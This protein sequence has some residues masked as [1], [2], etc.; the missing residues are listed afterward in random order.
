MPT[1]KVTVST[2]NAAPIRRNTRRSKES[3]GG[4]SRSGPSSHAP[5]CAVACAACRGRSTREECGQRRTKRSGGERHRIHQL[6]P[7]EDAFDPA[8]EDGQPHHDRERLR[9]AEAQFCRGEDLRVEERPVN[10]KRDQDGAALPRPQSCCRR[11]ASPARV[12]EM[13][14]QP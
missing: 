6:Y 5:L 8:D 13:P 2:A 7:I 12:P 9:E 14:R 4:T 11:T 10:S 1:T 3:N